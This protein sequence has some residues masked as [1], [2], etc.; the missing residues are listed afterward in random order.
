M[1]L[2]PLHK[3]SK[4]ESNLGKIIVA[5]GFECLPKRQKIAQSGHTDQRRPPLGG[6]ITLHLVSRLT[7][8][9]LTKTEIMCL[10][11]CS[12]AGEAKLVKL[13]NSHTVIIPPMFNVVCTYHLP[14]LLCHP[15]I[16]PFSGGSF[17]YLLSWSPI[18]ILFLPT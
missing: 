15:H 2:T 17:V 18:V 4:N 7:T 14:R 10:F 5:T 11:V 3:L 9:D 8:F 16:S 13:E 6:R 12:E 1:I